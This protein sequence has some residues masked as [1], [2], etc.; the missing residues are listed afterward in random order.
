MILK[1]R[2]SPEVVD[3]IHS[4]KILLIA[5]ILEQ[6]EYPS[7]QQL[8]AI[9]RLYQLILDAHQA[10]TL[11]FLEPPDEAVALDLLD[12]VDALAAAPLFDDDSAQ[13][14][15]VLLAARKAV[16]LMYAV[17]IAV[18]TCCVGA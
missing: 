10:D 14:Q 11:A 4:L 2:L 16:S 18:L 17:C 1:K 5:S 6:S 7:D 12:F 13:Y 3:P 8:H 15:E 9:M